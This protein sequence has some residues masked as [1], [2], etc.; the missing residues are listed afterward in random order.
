MTPDNDFRK[1]VRLLGDLLDGVLRANAPQAV[2]SA[3]ALLRGKAGPDT[4]TLAALEGETEPTGLPAADAR[5]LVKAFSTHFSLLNMAEQVQR[6]RRRR[7]Y[8]SDN[9]P[10]AGSLLDVIQ[11]LSQS[12][13]GADQL[14][15]TLQSLRVH[16]VFTAHPT[17]AERRSVL[18]KTQ[19]IARILIDR[20]EQPG[21]T[22]QERE[23]NIQRLLTE[24]TLL[25]QTEEH[26]ASGLTVA[27]E[28][29][30]VLFYLVEILYRVL[31]AFHEELGSAFR[32]TFG[33]TARFVPPARPISFGSW[34]G[35]DMDG[36]PYVDARTMRESLKRQRELIIER[37]LREASALGKQLSQSTSFATPELIDLGNASLATWPE[38]RETLPARHREMPYRVMLHVLRHRLAAVL[39]G[40]PAAYGSPAEMLADLELMVSSLR[41]HGGSGTSLPLLERFKCRVRCFGFHL[42]TLDVRQDSLVI[43]DAVAEL[44]GDPEFAQRDAA[45]RTRQ[46]EEAIASADWRTPPADDGVQE[47]TRSALNVLRA[48][49]Q[50][51]TQFGDEAIGPFIL[52]MARG[53]DDLLALQYLALVAGL[54]DP[55]ST[56]CVTLDLV[57]LF[58]TV[59]DLDGATETMAALFANPGYSR[60]LKAR[61]MRQ[62]VMLGYSDSSKSAGIA[63][64]RW[65]LYKAQESLIEL[66]GS[67]G[68][69]LELF[70]GRGGTV[71]RGGGKPRQAIL[72][73]PCGAVKGHLR[74]TEQGETIH[75][76][77]G[78]RGIALRTLE[79]YAGALLET[80][81]LCSPRQH[82]DPAWS[83]VIEEI[84]RNSRTAYRDLVDHEAFHDYF[85]LATPIDVIERLNIGSRPASRRSGR[86]VE[87]LRAIPWVFSWVQNRH[88]LPGWYGLGHGLEAAIDQHGV[89][90]LKRMASEWP[91]FR[92]LLADAESSLAKADY[93]IA[94]RYAALAGEAG[95]T[96]FPVVHEAFKQCSRLVT[97]LRGEQALLDSEPV[98]QGSIRSRNPFVDPMSLIQ[99][100]LLARWRD[101]DRQDDALLEALF[102]TV[103]GIARGMGNTG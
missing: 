81:A 87:N 78:L 25:W 83:R 55:S 31:P 92:T 74:M 76:K 40:G 14:L 77:Y 43:R 59:Q 10:Q 73:D 70:H 15:V 26:S 85:R 28:R 16:P 58:E 21:M 48:I 71:G 2:S 61:G 30:F 3:V 38:A 65:S 22:R 47:A 54:E 8:L 52:S 90:L 79:L 75:L 93:A 18:D 99:V 41:K 103:R 36:N 1:D 101:T 100:D 57:P 72:A 45:A 37:Y 17:R 19:H 50:L 68:I 88:M 7:A 51:R 46:L 12:G 89:E 94:G 5:L 32:E 84:G 29:E 9:H 67:Q 33:P 64:S 23:R 34:V 80:T 53:V 20:I 66:T 27:D 42:V 91:F 97:T 24:I 63:S 6:I 13:I 39:A 96:I 95:A 82:A 11:R 60:Q 62:M 56:S 44:L 4:S 35:G 69:E 86:G 98:L 49:R 102:E